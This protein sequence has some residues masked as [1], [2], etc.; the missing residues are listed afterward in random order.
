MELS[1]DRKQELVDNATRPGHGGVS[2]AGRALQSHASRVGS[3]LKS[4]PAAGNAAQNTTAARQALLEILADGQAVEETHPVWGDIIKVRLADG[5]GAVWKI[6]GTFITFLER[7][8][9]S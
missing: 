9:P 4:L 5:A 1:S 6:D 2:E 3:W 8:S 7:Y